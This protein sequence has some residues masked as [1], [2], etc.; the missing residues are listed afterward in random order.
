MKYKIYVCIYFVFFS[1]IFAFLIPPFEAPDEQL[2]LQY[3]NYISKYKTLPDQYEGLRVNEKYV[4]Q[5]H[6]HP[7]YYILTGTLNY[8]FNSDGVIS[9]NLIPNKNHFWYGGSEG[10]VPAFNHVYNNV[11][12]NSEDRIIFYIIRAFSIIF[13]LFTILFVFKIS[14]LFFTD[15]S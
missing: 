4:G 10:K 14:R 3:I 13:C 2:H 9:Y 15:N 8:L 1:L 7:L 11:F 6:Q 12:Q 5:G